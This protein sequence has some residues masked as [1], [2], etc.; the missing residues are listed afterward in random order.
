M[1]SIDGCHWRSRRLASAV[2]KMVFALFCIHVIAGLGKRVRSI[3]ALLDMA[4][5][6]TRPSPRRPGAFPVPPAADLSKGGTP[7]SGCAL[8]SLLPPAFGGSGLDKPGF[9][10]ATQE[11]VAARVS[12]YALGCPSIAA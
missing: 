6:Y 10:I 8:G 5:Q 12:P 2:A 11:I 3:T 9:L 4:T 7:L 1:K